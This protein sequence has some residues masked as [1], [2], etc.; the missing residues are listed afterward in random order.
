V[1]PGPPVRVEDDVDEGGGNGWQ[2]LGVQ[3]E[4]TEAVLRALNGMHCGAGP[5][6]GWMDGGHR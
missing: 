1:Q 4:D 2:R 6:S 5:C 3:R